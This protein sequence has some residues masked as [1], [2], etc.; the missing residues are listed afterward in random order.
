MSRRARR[1]RVLD[2]RAEVARVA[3]RGSRSCGNGVTDVSTR[4]GAGGAAKT[5]SWSRLS[6]TWIV[7]VVDDGA[8]HRLVARR[9]SLP[10]VARAVTG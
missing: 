5:N 4:N 2:V 1:H 10:T 9:A 6:G 8:H 3:D 7:F